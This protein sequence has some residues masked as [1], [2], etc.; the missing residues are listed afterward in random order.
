MAKRRDFGTVRQMKSGRWQ[1]RY[2][3]PDGLMRPGERV[4]ATK[5]EAQLYLSQVQSQI[6]GGR[7]ID[8]ARQKIL[9]GD[10]ADH[11]YAVRDL[12]LTTRDLYERLLRVHI[13]PQLGAVPLGRITS[14]M[15]REWHAERRLATGKTTVRQAY[16]LLRTIM[17]TAV[18]DDLIAKSP[19]DIKG[20][21]SVQ[22]ANR[23]TMSREQAHALMRAMPEDMQVFYLVT[24][25]THLRRGELLGLRRG[26]VDLVNALLFI[27]NNRVRTNAGMVEKAPK[28]GE[29]RTVVMPPLS[30]E[31]MRLYMAQTGP[32]DHSEP[33]FK[34]RG[35]G[36]LEPHH[37]RY[38]WDRA[39]E[40]TGL[41]EFTW[42]DLRHAGL[43]WFAQEG[44][45]LREIMDRG[46]HKS[47]EA[48]MRYQHAS[49]DRK[50]ELAARLTFAIEAPD[51]GSESAV[52][53]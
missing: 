12:A 53:A 33:L 51:G 43:T 20:A 11:W 4:F 46:G 36:R 3:G 52:S 2:R 17:N 28:S 21:A 16:S 37:L 1:A 41:T 14:P 44:A 9:L 35:G 31:A 23:P 49:E 10:Y 7:W 15:I 19:C 34:H 50:Y 38:A 27:R 39:R 25:Q 5:G 40:V 47:I 48:A 8:P 32:A 42:H 6:H 30:R 26:D 18:S 13:K 24:I 45:T 22:P 29:S